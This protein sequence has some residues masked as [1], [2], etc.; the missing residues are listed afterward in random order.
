MNLEPFLL[1]VYRFS[2]VRLFQTLTVATFVFCLLSRRYRKCRWWRPLLALSLCAWLAV[3]LF[4]TLLRR[5]TGDYGPFRW[6]LFHSY[7]D[8]FAGDRERL[9]SNLMNLCLFYPGGLFLCGLLPRKWSRWGKVLTVF[10][11]ICPMS[12]GIELVQFRFQLGF[13]EIDDVFH[14]TLGSCAGCLFSMP[15]RI[16]MNDDDT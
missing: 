8:F 10:L 12:F 9:R 4:A 11:L 15:P 13:G 14:N 6:S 1:W 2:F 5:G 7:R 16:L 3:V